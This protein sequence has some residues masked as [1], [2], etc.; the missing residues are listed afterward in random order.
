MWNIVEDLTNKNSTS[1]SEQ[2]VS[3][4]MLNNFFIEIA[5]KIIKDLPQTESTYSNIQHNSNTIFLDQVT[6]SEILNIIS[7]LKS[8]KSTDVNGIS[9]HLIKIINP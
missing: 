4:E 9:N 5:D 6:P 7:S 8:S 3:T 2:P 1:N